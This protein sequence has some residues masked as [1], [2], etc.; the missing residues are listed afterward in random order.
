ME[1][2][3]Y[4]KISNSFYIEKNYLQKAEHK[5]APHY[6]NACEVFYFLLGEAKYFV[7]NQCYSVKK[8]SIIFVDAYEIHKAL[9][10][11]DNCERAVLL[12]HPAV[13]RYNQLIN[14]PDIF[15]ILNE[16]FNGSRL[17]SLPQ[18]LQRSTKDIIMKMLEHYQAESSYKDAFLYSYLNIFITQIAE[19]LATAGIPADIPPLNPHISD[20]LSYINQ[21][22]ENEISLDNIST[23]L[24]MSKYHLCRIFK[25][26]TG[27]TIVDYVN[28]KR[29]LTAEKLIG[30][31]KYSFTEIASRVGFNNLIHFERVFR[32]VTGSNPRD[33]KKKIS[34][35]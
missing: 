2:S 22:I 18:D 33:Y 26:N 23:H 25:E 5:S 1:N 12:Y 30:L 11:S 3:R 9:Y 10:T 4:E 8:G 17:I 15:R 21:N 29:I 24:N 13:T 28:R 19:Y 32:S 31:G 14:V 20:I 16:K 6:H 7:H 35:F 34:A 27:L